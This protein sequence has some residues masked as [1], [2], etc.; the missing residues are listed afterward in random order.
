MPLTALSPKTKARIAGLCYLVTIAVGV[1]DHLVVA[2]RL[3]VPGDAAA[4]AQRMMASEGLY[5]LAFALEMFPVYVVVTVLL[6]DLFRPVDRSL[7]LLAAFCS[8]IGGAV[9]SSIAVLQLAPVVALGHVPAVASLPI[10]QRH[11]LVGILLALRQ[12][13][14]SISLVFFGSYCALLGWLILGSTL[15][16]RA[17]GALVGVGGIAWVTY[18]LAD[19][20]APAVGADLGPWAL[21]LGTL[22]EGALTI[23]LLAF[24]VKTARRHEPDQG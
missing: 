8:L 13:G 17:V 12:V 3:V 18:A 15:M 23:W 1:F 21:L 24:G 10:D 16:P 6:Y 20:A 19:L 14:F 2:G 22:G 5:R 11:A 4:T 9:G 7:A